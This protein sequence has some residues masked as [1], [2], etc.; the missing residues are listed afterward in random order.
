MRCPRGPR[1]TTVPIG[2]ELGVG[3]DIFAVC[4]KCGDTWHVIVALEGAK[5]TKVQCKFC[6][7]YHRF[8]RSPNDPSPM[9]AGAA[10]RSGF[11]INANGSFS[12]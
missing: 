9:P 10:C 8:K 7:G 12:S 2:M 6:S 11:S 5:V 4:G 3:K 1:S